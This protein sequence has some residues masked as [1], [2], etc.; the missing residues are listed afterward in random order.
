MIGCINFIAKNN[1]H[2]QLSV[3]CPQPSG[4]DLCKNDSCQD[5]GRVNARI[6]IFRIKYRIACFPNSFDRISNNLR[7]IDAVIF[8]KILY[9]INR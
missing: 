2:V 6:R 7:S 8:S 1:T 5:M 3:Q 4:H 9:G